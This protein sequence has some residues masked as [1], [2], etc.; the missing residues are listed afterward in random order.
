MIGR[1]ALAMRRQP[2]RDTAARVAMSVSSSRRSASSVNCRSSSG[3]WT[4][5]CKYW[6]VM[7]RSSV[8]LMSTP[9]SV[10]IEQAFEARHMWQFHHEGGAPSRHLAS[11]HF[12]NL[13]VSR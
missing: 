4:G 13:S 5:V 10:E 1:G 7:T 8:G 3:V 6:S 9:L 2:R 11:F 12:V